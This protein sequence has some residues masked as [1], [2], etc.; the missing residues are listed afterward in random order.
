MRTCHCTLPL[1][2][3]RACENCP[4]SYTPQTVGQ[5]LYLP[6]SPEQ[7]DVDFGDDFILL[8]KKK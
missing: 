2:N 6:I 3:P 8:R 1:T 5:P 4:N 7:W